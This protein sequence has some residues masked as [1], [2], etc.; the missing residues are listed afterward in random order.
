MSAVT[1][2]T[3]S[4][5]ILSSQKLVF[6]NF[7]QKYLALELIALEFPVVMTYLTILTGKD[8]GLGIFF[9]FEVESVMKLLLHE[10]FD[11]PLLQFLLWN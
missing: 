10:L 7:S 11:P 3:N 4:F 5:V 1:F 2:P 6:S 8:A 9:E